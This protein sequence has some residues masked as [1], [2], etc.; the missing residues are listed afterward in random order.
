MSEE[1][2]KPQGETN[3]EEGSA[4]QFMNSI[5]MA[6]NLGVSAHQA[7]GQSKSVV[8]IATELGNQIYQNFAQAYSGEINEAFLKANT[9]YFLQIAL[10]G[11]I[12]PGVCA[13][14]NDFKQKLFDLVY[15]RA[16]QNQQRQAESDGTPPGG[17]R[18]IT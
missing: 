3:S 9:E 14:D 1:D 7:S 12:I 2:T 4:D 5:N 11:Y 6:F 16:K 10:M 8:E 13:F 17:S 15:A 18:I